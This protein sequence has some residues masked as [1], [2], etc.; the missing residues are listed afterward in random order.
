M[1]RIDR[2]G[3]TAFCRSL[4]TVSALAVLALSVLTALLPAQEGSKPQGYPEDWS[5]HH[6]VFSNPG[7]YEQAVQNGTVDKWTK[8]TNDQRYKIQQRARSRAAATSPDV[9]SPVSAAESVPIFRGPPPVK[10]TAKLEKDWST[11]LSGVAAFLTG[12]V[13]ATLNSSTL[14]SSSTLTVD[15]VELFASAPTAATAT[16]TFTAAP[17][18]ATAPTITV[19]SGSNSTITL[20]TNATAKTVTGTVASGNPGAPLTGQTVV[21][22]ST[23]GSITLTPGGTAAT[24]TGSVSAAFTTGTITLVYNNGGGTANTLSLTPSA[25]TQG[26]VVGTF[27]ASGGSTGQFTPGTTAGTFA[28]TS[29][30]NTATLTPNGYQYFT[31]S[32]TPCT[33]GNGNPCFGATDTVTIDGHTFTFA[34]S[35]TA[36]GTV[37]TGGSADAAAQ[38]LAAA[39]M[40]NSAMCVTSPCFGTAT[41]VTGLSA[42]YDTSGHTYIFNSTGASFTISDNASSRISESS[43][44]VTQGSNS[45]SG[46][47]PT[48][49]VG[50]GAVAT[51]SG[52][53][54]SSAANMALAL[55]LSGCSTFGMTATSTALTITATNTAYGAT[56]A[57]SASE[58]LGG[59]SSSA[60]AGTGTSG[61]SNSSTGQFPTYSGIT[62]AIEASNISSAINTCH[63]TYSA[64]GAT[65]SYTSGSTFLVTAAAPGSAVTLTGTVPTGFSWSASTLGNDTGAGTCTSATA[66]TFINSGV[67]GTLASDIAAALNSSSCT[68]S[69]GNSGVTATY[70]SG[71]TFT[72]AANLLGTSPTFTTG[73]GTATATTWGTT[74]GGSNGSAGCS[75]SGPWT[76]TFATSTT[77]TTIEASITTAITDCSSGTKGVT[78]SGDAV[79]TNTVAGTGTALNVGGGNS[80]FSWSSTAGT[81]GT[82]SGTT[83]A[84]WSGAG[85]ATPAAI[86]AN[87][88]TAINTNATLQS[89][90]SSPPPGVSAN[91]S[92]TSSVVITYNETGA[93]T[94]T[95][96]AGSFSAWSQTSL[97]A[98]TS[99][100]VARVQPNTYPAKYSFSTTTA[101][102]SDFVVYPTGTVGAT[103]AST[104]IAYSNLYSGCSSSGGVPTLYWSYNTGTG[105]AIT[106]SPV[107]SLDGTQIAFIQSNGT[108]A[109]LVLLTWTANATA[110]VNAPGAATSV[111]AGSYNTCTAP[112]YTAITL[113]GST[114]DTFSAPFYDYRGDAL[115]VGDDSGN[116]HQFTGVFNGTPTE[117]T[118]PWPQNLTATAKLSSPVYDAQWNAVFVGDFGGLLHCVLLSAG[119]CQGG[120]ATANLGGAIADAPLINSAA[121]YVIAFVSDDTVYGFS[122][123]FFPGGQGGPI[124]VGTGGTVDYLYA[125]TFDN[126]YYQSSNATGN[127]YVVGNTGT[128]GGA[129]LYQLPLTAGFLNGTAA[130]VVTGLNTGSLPWPSPVSEFCNNGA[131]AC[132]LQTAT[133]CSISTGAT[134][135]VNCT[136]GGFTSADVGAWITG[137]DIPSGATIT[138]V[139]SGTKIIISAAGTV[140][141]VGTATIGV[142]TTGIDYLFFSVNRG[143]VSGCTTTAGNGCIL[144]YNI[145]SP[146]SSSIVEVGSGLNVTTPGSSGCWATGGLIIDNSVL[147]G[148]LAGASELYFVNLSGATAGNPSSVTSSGCTSVGTAT[149]IDAVQ[150]SQTNP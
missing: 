64:V 40:Q 48:F 105:Y 95:V 37:D 75:G 4:W 11:T 137:T 35:G 84:Y 98:G 150:A 127:I 80:I 99:G 54:S 129:T 106:T 123:Q 82:T 108:S 34:S 38:N 97:T 138:T 10:K 94:F 135:T 119:S 93:I 26:N 16:G 102:C 28:V 5:H 76:A 36:A 3:L 145:S 8:I 44:T 52:G 118:T 142:T 112:C 122:E 18:T 77:L 144:S 43:G 70:T 30:S 139:S 47:A 53:T 15:G 125:G 104:I 39:V 126:G 61:C 51:T 128:A 31:I 33:G 117:S 120:S 22:P 103:A 55:N 114:N 136:G 14:S 124:G 111:S 73:T 20:T 7:T 60:T 32:S 146:H 62:T 100:T 115:Y 86:A 46:S 96:T 148:T 92:G 68:G 141:T 69:P 132:A 78:A 130:S 12:T 107:M 59:F 9:A 42:S 72:V 21:A 1:I 65:S 131:S 87:I 50:F 57:V 149:I 25:A 17:T 81:D 23:T 83:F 147:S 85:Y 56:P 134:T 49:T 101:L 113:S 140:G 2:S 109:Q 27:T 121:N 13:G 6:L 24:M 63:G 88:A 91:T 66:G 110:A 45:C 89:I 90:T 71:N 116:L 41:T 133:G 74:T 143:N 79:V 29:G 67:S 58:S 19:Q